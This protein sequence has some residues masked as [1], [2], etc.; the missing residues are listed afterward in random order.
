MLE[1]EVL[2]DSDGF[3]E[4]ERFKMF[5]V[6]LVVCSTVDGLAGSWVGWYP[7]IM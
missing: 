3:E 1:E 4:Q 5:K 2:T 6:R 7:S